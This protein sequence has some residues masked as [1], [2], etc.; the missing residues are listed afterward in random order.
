MFEWRNNSPQFRRHTDYSQ[1]NLF[2]RLFAIN[3]KKGI[4]IFG[5]EI[6]GHIRTTLASKFR[7]DFI[8]AHIGAIIL[9]ARWREATT[10][11]FI[12]LVPRRS[13]SLIASIAA[14]MRDPVRRSDLDRTE[15][16]FEWKR[17]RL[18]GS[19]GRL[20]LFSRLKGS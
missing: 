7:F 10:N 16:G 6:L 20:R 4:A 5:W 15:R 14:S 8:H 18:V 17:G 12:M 9:R 2:S 3:L 19:S 11:N 1:L 13:C